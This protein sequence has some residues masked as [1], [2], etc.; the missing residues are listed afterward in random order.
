MLLSPSLAMNEALFLILFLR[1]NMIYIIVPLLLIAKYCCSTHTMLCSIF[2]TIFSL[3]NW[4]KTCTS[5]GLGDVLLM[6]EIAK[7]FFYVSIA[8][9]STVRAL[10]SISLASQVGYNSTVF[11]IL[12]DIQGIFCDISF[13]WLPLPLY[14]KENL[15][16]FEN[17]GETFFSLSVIYST[18]AEIHCFCLAFKRG[19]WFTF[20]N[21]RLKLALTMLLKAYISVCNI[22]H[23]SSWC[24]V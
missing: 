12:V 22:N 6:G 11:C 5:D 10:N 13:S 2:N 14:P 20:R 4:H 3:K 17:H 15:F 24:T 23:H 19:D 18:N 1:G 8:V 7:L 9:L 21:V 16:I